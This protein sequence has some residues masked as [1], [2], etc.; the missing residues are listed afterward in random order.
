M[1]HW[2]SSKASKGGNILDKLQKDI[3]SKIPQI[4]MPKNLNLD[5]LPKVNLKYIKDLVDQVVK[6]F[7]QPSGSK[8]TPGQVA[9][10]GPMKFPYTFSAKLAQFPYKFYFQNNWVWRYYP[11]GIVACLPIFCQ[12]KGKQ[13]GMESYTTT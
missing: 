12:L 7:H 2:F 9:S 3:K 13:R 6:S 11:I 8:P 1:K 10:S 5:Q 4:Q